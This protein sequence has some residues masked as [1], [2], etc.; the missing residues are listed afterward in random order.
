MLGLSVIGI[1]VFNFLSPSCDITHVDH[2]VD[3]C[4]SAL[5]V[6]DSCESIM[7]SC[8]IL[9]TVWVS[10]KISNFQNI[11]K[12]LSFHEF[13]QIFQPFKK[14]KKIKNSKNFQIF[15]SGY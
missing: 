12:H 9:A 1:I 15:K 5:L 8:M 4:E 14:L 7:L 2:D 10:F 3:K 6:N 13:F 11:Q